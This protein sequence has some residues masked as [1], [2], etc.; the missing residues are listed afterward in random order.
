MPAVRLLYTKANGNTTTYLGNRQNLPG[1]KPWFTTPRSRR[2]YRKSDG[3]QDC[4]SPGPAAGP[5]DWRSLAG[6]CLWLFPLVGADLWFTS[7]VPVYHQLAFGLFR[8]GALT[9]GSGYAML[10]FIRETVVARYHWLSGPEFNTA[11]TFSLMRAGHHH[12][13]LYR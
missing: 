9:F 3:K 8:I 5:F 12:R 13:R 10:P 4:D 1:R 2:R 11:L 7:R 6:N